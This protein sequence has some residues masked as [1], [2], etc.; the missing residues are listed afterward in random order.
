MI[1]DLR[2]LHSLTRRRR[3][4]LERN[5]EHHAEG[6]RERSVAR[7]RLVAVGAQAGVPQAR[8][9]DQQAEGLKGDCID[10]R[11]LKNRTTGLT[12]IACRLRYVH[13]TGRFEE[14]AADY[15]DTPDPQSWKDE[16]TERD[17]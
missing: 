15:G 9:R 14:V 16:T 7:G 10:V 11:V 6:V 3:R 13:E 12:G 4:L 8:E 1:G 17:F 5:G 2:G